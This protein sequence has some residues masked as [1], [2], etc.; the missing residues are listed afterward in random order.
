MSAT[1]RQIVKLA[2]N[3]AGNDFKRVSVLS[4]AGTLNFEGLISGSTVEKVSSL[5][6]VT[7]ADL[8]VA[9]KI[10]VADGLVTKEGL[11]GGPLD[12]FLLYALTG[13]RTGGVLAVREDLAKGTNARITLPAL[14]D[15]VDVF[16]RDIGGKYVG[17]DFYCAEQLDSS[18][19][20][21]SNYLDFVWIL[22]K[23]EFTPPAAD[24][25]TVTFRDF[26]DKTQYTNTGIGAY[27]WMF[28]KDF[29]SPG[30]YDENIRV[31]EQFGGFEYGGKMLDIGS[32]IG[33]GVRQAAAVYGLHVTGVDLSANMLTE[34]IVRVHD[35]KESRVNYSICDAVTYDFG[36]NVYDYIF[37]RDC[38]QHITDQDA[39][40]KNIYRSLKPGGVVLITMYGKGKGAWTEAFKKYNDKRFYHLQTLDEVK[41][42]AIKHGFEAV[43]VENMTERFREILTSERAH[44][45]KEKEDFFKH[46]TQAE[47]DSLFNGWSDKL[48]Y[49]EADNHNWNLFRARK[50][51]H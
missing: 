38:I 29:I 19:H 10:L 24:A 47:F 26:L 23:K 34:A 7:E 35:E 40:F 44:L 18:I 28:G 33:G 20:L 51:A 31:L 46:Y 22:R 4:K 17:F 27:E 14:T 8:I 39:L 2:R 30:G 15:Y 37:S 36:E 48:K 16:R 49:I 1:E 9:D 11:Q 32:G 41:E 6:S 45:E 5:D 3:A 43:H 42:R 50:P 25:A 21:E 13:L 12:M